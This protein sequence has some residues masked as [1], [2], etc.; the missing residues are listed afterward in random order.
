[1]TE[2][3]NQSPHDQENHPLF[4]S[5]DLV[6][7]IRISSEQLISATQDFIEWTNDNK[8][9]VIEELIRV[10]N[11][12]D[13]VIEANPITYKL[14]NITDMTGINE[15]TLRKMLVDVGVDIN[16]STTDS[17]ENI[18]QHDL[19]TLLADRA[20][21]KEGDLLAEFIRSNRRIFPNC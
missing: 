7:K 3:K 16:I 8:N 4:N 12:C 5:V 14:V 13:A 9:I 17:E 6:D 21:S 18:T 19:I 2:I 15:Q 11:F 1:M 10:R 20:G